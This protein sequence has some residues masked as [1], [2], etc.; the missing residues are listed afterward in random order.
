MLHHEKEKVLSSIRSEDELRRELVIPLLKKMNIFSDVLDNQGSNEAGVDVIGVSTSPFKKPEYTAFV[1]K[2]GD[3]TLKV[4]DQ[5]NN[6]VNIVETQIRQAIK[7]PLT[8]PRLPS[9]RS[10]ASRVL[11]ITNGSISNNAESALKR[12]F[13]QL[14]IDFVGKDRLID[15]IDALWPRFY[16]DRRPFLSS[17]AVKLFSTLDVVSL[18]E[19][20]Y[21]KRKRSLSDIY[22]DSLL[23]EEDSVASTFDFDFDKHP[24][25]GEQLCKQRHQL[26]AITSGP[27]GGKTTLLKE[28]AISQ[29]KEEKD[30]VAVYFH[31]REV[32][33]TK[34]VLRQAAENLALLSNETVADVYEE[35]KTAKL[36]FIVDGLD[37]LAAVA[38]R[39][40]VIRGLVDAHRSLGARVI[41]GT[42][43]ESNPSVVAALSSFKAYSISPLR[44]SQIRSFFGKWFSDSADKASKLIGALED[45]GVLDKLPRTPMTMTLVAIVYES[46]EDIP[47]TLT[48]LYEMFVDLLTG[49]WDSNR[50]ISSPFDSRMKLSFL[51]RLAA[52]MQFERLDFISADRAL[53][54]ADDFFKHEATLP[55]VDPR[56][57]IQSIIDRSHILIPTGPD[58]LRF[59]HMTFQEYFAADHL[60]RD[61]PSNPT[62][63]EWF[64]DDWWKEVLFFLAGKKQNIAPIV[65]ALLTADYEPP[66]TRMTKLTTLGS[67]LQ[68]GTLTNGEQKSKAVRFA[69]ERF[70]SCF[71]DFQEAIKSLKSAKIRGRVSRVML[72]H[73]VQ[74]LFTSN[75]CSTYLKQSLLDTYRQL[76]KQLDYQGAR[77]FVA[78]A[79][80]KLGEYDPMLEFATEPAMVDASM[81]VL[82]GLGLSKR[83][84]SEEDQE[85]YRRLRKRATHFR[86]AIK[87]ELGPMFGTAP[88]HIAKKVR[89]KR[90][91]KPS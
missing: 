60:S 62:I 11:V 66:G 81:Y 78:S 80:S 29:S 70:L 33:E 20:G 36:L 9:E 27:G 32:L 72:M 63:L 41:V 28:I 88:K 16:E 77:F 54:L 3:I 44:K 24:I 23:Y 18:E 74:E 25:A 10:Y 90:K 55:D 84:L 39:E 47:S 76:P 91:K 53:S 31:A 61:F 8:H 30:Q 43:P 58:E 86:D 83:D 35:I 21:A 6:L 12:S 73:I 37:E 87:K 69:S 56:A 45:K 19:L 1:L 64:G 13:P 50:K 48:E 57:F 68:A 5:R 2:L 65:E 51:G 14:N 40:Q 42:R 79:L 34:D 49:K 26:I 85:R 15:H 4:A 38:D 46:K 75:F 52:T 82:S 17:Y 71:D 67:M 7:H 59:S 22:I 89:P